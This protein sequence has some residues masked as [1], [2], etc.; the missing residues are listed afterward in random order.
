MRERKTTEKVSPEIINQMRV[1][2][3]QVQLT[4]IDWCNIKNVFRG[5]K[6]KKKYNR[7]EERKFNKKGL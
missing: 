3:W 2:G 5:G 7:K 6:R 4:H 1:G